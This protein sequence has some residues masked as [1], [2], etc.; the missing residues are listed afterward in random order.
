[1]GIGTR[2]LVVVGAGWVAVTGCNDVDTGPA[3]GPD[4][5]Q[6]L[7]YSEDIGPMIDAHC[8]ICHNDGGTAPF[9]L[10]TYEQVASFAEVML[11][12][13]DSRSMPPWGA[14]PGHRA[15]RYD[16]S[17][18]DAQIEMFAEWIDQ[19]KP[20][21]DRNNPGDPIDLDLGGLDRTDVEIAMKHEYTPTTA[22]D[23]Y[24]CFVIDWPRE[25]TAYITGYEGK[26]G[27]RSVVHHLVIF[28][29]GPGQVDRLAEFEQLD[30]QPGYACFGGV[31]PTQDGKTID[32]FA[33]IQGQL[34]GQWA[35]GLGGQE[36]TE[37]TGVRVEPGSKAVLQVHYNVQQ[38]GTSA[39][40]SMI[41]F[42]VDESVEREGAMVAFLDASWYIDPNT[43]LIPAGQQATHEYDAVLLSSIGNTPFNDGA[44]IHAVLPHMHRLGRTIELV[45]QAGCA[46]EEV[47][48][49][50]PDYDFNWQRDYAFKQPV[51]YHPGE[52]LKIKCAWDNTREWRAKAGVDPIEPVDVVWGEGTV[53]EM[54]V[55][56]MY[57]TTPK[58]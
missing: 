40:R 52:R 11:Q 50:I 3:V 28:M 33:A 12:A 57:V 27:N 10:N 18:S 51:R 4:D 53:D 23:E 26:P 31:A 35:P 6:L 21:G 17:L 24:R 29:V 8:G 30:E 56:A 58:Q 5:T 7:G 48:L 19:G 25:E 43:M 16:P 9:S 55:A 15:L 34:I 37:G 49:R 54:C 14:E 46:S 42:R 13:M 41:G 32:E 36:F 39:D 1:M 38:A 44:E 22:P 20:E 47:L 2:G 45:K